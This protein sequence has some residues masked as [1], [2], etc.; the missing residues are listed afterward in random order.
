MTVHSDIQYNYCYR[1]EE[2]GDEIVHCDR[3]ECHQV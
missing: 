1:K 2:L 3:E